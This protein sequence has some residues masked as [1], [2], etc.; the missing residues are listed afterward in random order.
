[1]VN[2]KE[3]EN[4]LISFINKKYNDET[5]NQ[6]E[7]IICEELCLYEQEIDYY[8]DED[9]EDEYMIVSSFTNKEEDI[10]IKIYY[11]NNTFNIFDINYYNNIK[12]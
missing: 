4:E 11:G 10:T 2:F 3:I 12:L 7:K 8:I 6:L 1:M 9:V 5:I